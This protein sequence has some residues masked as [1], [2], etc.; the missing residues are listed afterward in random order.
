MMIWLDFLV[1][2]IPPAGTL[3]EVVGRSGW[4]VMSGGSTEDST[5]SV[6]AAGPEAVAGMPELGFISGLLGLDGNGIAAWS[7]EESG[8]VVAMDRLE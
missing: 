8:S 5:M 3:C 4:T 6:A 2:S 1:F 7:C